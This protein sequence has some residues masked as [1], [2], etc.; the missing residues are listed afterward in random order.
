MKIKKELSEE[1]GLSPIADLKPEG[2]GGG[3][4]ATVLQGL[5]R[6]STPPIFRIYF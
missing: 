4:D 3:V 1:K 5:P 2:K 6:C